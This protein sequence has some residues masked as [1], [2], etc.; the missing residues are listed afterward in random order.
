MTMS[1][2]STIRVQCPTCLVCGDA[3]VMTVDAAAFAAW[4]RGTLIQV[5]FPDLSDAQRE[6]LK[7]GYH[8]DCWDQMFEGIE[9]ED[10]AL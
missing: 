9:D 2:S 6:Q 7:T 1:T 10:G 3:S 5:A 4:N 8:A